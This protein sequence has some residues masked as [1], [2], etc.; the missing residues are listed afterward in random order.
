[1]R[2]PVIEML[3]QEQKNTY[4]DI[5]ISKARNSEVFHGSSLVFYLL[6]MHFKLARTPG[7]AIVLTNKLC[8]QQTLGWHNNAKKVWGRQGVLAGNA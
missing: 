3:A 7:V 1:M 4:F 5:P 6:A 2:L 8:C